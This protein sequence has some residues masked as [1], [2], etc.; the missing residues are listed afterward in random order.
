MARKMTVE[1]V[2]DIDGSAAEGTRTFSLDGVEYEIDLSSANGGKLDKALEK[3][4]Q[5]ARRVGGRKKA[6]RSGAPRVTVDREQ[7]QAI[8]DWATKKGLKVSA[9]G[10]ISQEVVDAYSNQHKTPEFTS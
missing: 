4:V 8:R 9:R 7:T 6:A 3:W 5:H 10:R 1:F 2:D